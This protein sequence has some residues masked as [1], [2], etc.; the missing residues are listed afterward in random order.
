MTK[1]EINTERRL[2]MLETKLDD[3]C[4]SNEEHFKNIEAKLDKFIDSADKK[5]APAWIGKAVYTIIILIISALVGEAVSAL[6]K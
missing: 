5:Y 6:F 1:S 2:T 3:H 4:K